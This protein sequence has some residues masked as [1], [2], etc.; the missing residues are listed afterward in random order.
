MT[1]QIFINLPVGDLEKSTMFYEA[2][3]FKKNPL[4]SDDN[5]SSMMWSDEIVVMLLRHDFYQTF[6]KEKS[7]IDAKVVSG[8][9]LALSLESK[10]AVQEFANTAKANGGDFYKAGPET[11]E[12]MMFGYEV[13]DPDGHVWEPVWMNPN[14]NPQQQ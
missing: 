5:A 7:I 11:P 2:L 3:G 10:D 14:F 6:I 12:D 1:K 8:V 13:T 9:L 4:F